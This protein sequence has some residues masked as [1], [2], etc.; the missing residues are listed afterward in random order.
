MRSLSRLLVLLAAAAA[1]GCATMEPPKP[2]ERG[3]LAKSVDADRPRQAGTEDPAAHLHEQGGGDRRLRRR[4][5]RVWLQLT[6]RD[7]RGPPRSRARRRSARA[8]RHA[9]CGRGGA[10]GR[11]SRR[12]RAQVPRLSRLAA[13]REPDDGAQPVALHAHPRQRHDGA[14]S[15]ARLRRDVGRLAA[16]LQHAVGRVGPGRH[17]LPDRRRREGDEVLRR[18]GGR[19]GRRRVV[20]A[21][22][23]LARRARSTSGST[24]PIATAR[25]R[26]SIAGANDRINPTNGAVS[27]APRNTLEYLVGITQALS[28]TQIVQSNLTYS[29]GHGYYNDP[30]KVARHAARPSGASSRGSRATTS[31]SPSRRAHS[32]CRTAT[33]TIRSAAIRT[34]SPPR[35]CRRCRTSGR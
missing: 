20:R 33:C 13:R 6:A 11:R 8:A 7:R 31:T 23:P 9:A 26:S 34:R 27:N 2:W 18:L 16:V 30:Y 25:T 3:D 17:R 10:G 32:G 19:R 22:L 21:R 15:L 4:R 5:G 28:P 1:V 14:R 29:Y 12:A 35:G 24:R